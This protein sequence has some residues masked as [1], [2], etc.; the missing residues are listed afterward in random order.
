MTFGMVDIHFSN[1]LKLIQ[2]LQRQTHLSSPGIKSILDDSTPHSSCPIA[3]L[4]ANARNCVPCIY[5]SKVENKGDEEDKDKES[6]GLEF[7]SHHRPT[8]N[9]A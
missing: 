4:S 8:I 9:V 6:K 7:A 2:V 3:T 5:C 1:K